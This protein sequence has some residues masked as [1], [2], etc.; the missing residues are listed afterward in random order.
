MAALADA[1]SDTL[2]LNGMVVAAREEMERA[3]MPLCPCASRR[4]GHHADGLPYAGHRAAGRAG[5]HAGGLAC[6]GHRAAGLSCAI[7]RT[8]G[9]PNCPPP[10]H[11]CVTAAPHRPGPSHPRAGPRR[12]PPPRAG[13]APLPPRLSPRQEPPRRRLLLTPSP[14]Q[15]PSPPPR[16]VP[17]PGATAAASPMAAC[18]CR[19]L[20][21]EW[22][23]F[24]GARDWGTCFCLTGGLF[25]I[26]LTDKRGPQ[27]GVQVGAGHLRKWEGLRPMTTGP[28]ERA[29][30]MSLT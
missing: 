8:A 3:P 6:T 26:F 18:P 25:Y 9:L 30:H 7:R 23:G 15:E 5:H 1:L 17:A 19:S 29:S 11:A 20:S 21:Q 13:G 4:A 14:R 28:L 2:C 24:G 10:Y 12:E 16:A 22:L 27:V